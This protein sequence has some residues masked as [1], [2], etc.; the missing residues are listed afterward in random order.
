MSLVTAAL[1]SAVLLFSG[2]QGER[3]SR[4]GSDG[5]R[6]PI[7]IISVD[8]LRADHLPAWGYKGVRTPAIDRLVSESV[9]FENAYAPTPLTLPSHVTILTGKQPYEHGVRNNYGYRYDPARHEPITAPL[10][11]AGYSTGAAVSAFPLRYE[12]GLGGAF[13]SYDG[14]IDA[15]S[16]QRAGSVTLDA[17]REWIAKSSSRPFM[18]FFHIY[19]PHQGWHPPEPFKSE[20]EHPY[21]GEI[22]TADSI[23]G[24]FLDYL[25]ANG[26]YD[27]ALII[28]LSDHGEGLGEHGETSHAVFVY[29]ETIH[30]P[31]IV[32]LPGSERAGERVRDV[33]QL[34]DV[35]PTIAGIA[36]VDP[37]RG[38]S[39]RDLFDPAA[40]REARRAYSESFYPRLQLGWS[41]LRSLIDDRYHYIEAPKPELYDHR[42]DPR[43]KANVIESERR[44]YAAM[45]KELDG[46]EKRLEGPESGDAEEARSLAALGYIGSDAAEGSTLPDPKDHIVD[47]DKVTQV[48]LR[49]RDGRINEAIALMRGVVERNP[50]DTNAWSYLADYLQRA[51]RDEDAA[52][53]YREA[54]RTS[55]RLTDAFAC[56]LA[57][58]LLRLGRTDEAESTAKLALDRDET[59]ARLL[60]ARIALVR[61]RLDTAESEI[62]RIPSDDLSRLRGTVVLSE[63]RQRQGRVDEAITILE[64]AREECINKRLRVDRLNLKL[65]ELYGSRGVREPAERA[66]RRQVKLF[67]ENPDGPAALAA[68]LA[69]SG[70][71]AEADAVL[72]DLVTTNPYPRALRL[73]AATAEGYGNRKL[74]ADYRRR[75]QNAP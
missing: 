19:E 22:A 68:F 57:E 11:R 34:S 59:N 50:L 44:S 13:E 6:P 72:A 47:Y 12:T 75:A 51:G 43:E 38:A 30:V 5:R 55:P 64:A 49:A 58:V 1:L 42:S 71:V 27:G 62:L 7:I 17:A 70:R 67:P 39:G 9:L 36:G 31:L 14:G 29:K 21:D 32:K 63:I 15:E 16:F 8:T 66:L 18:F 41:E 40:L 20:Y 2:C 35:A 48:P 73:A 46:I 65:G 26:L 3:S 53:A 60:L 45:R 69:E 61:E 52:V 37:P 25:R 4:G 56:R 23:V 33:V 54:L 24:Q 10:K 74:A 28:L